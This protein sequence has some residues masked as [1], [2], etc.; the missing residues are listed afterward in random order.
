MRLRQF[1]NLDAGF[2]VE[3]AQDHDR[4]ALKSRSKSGFRVRVKAA[5][6]IPPRDLKSRTDELV[7]YRSTHSAQAQYGNVGFAMCWRVSCCWLHKF[8]HVYSVYALGR[9]ASNVSP[10]YPP[11]EVP[12]GT[13]NAALAV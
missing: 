8:W 11:G 12:G 2:T 1:T 9:Y 7:S 6:A 4:C 13:A 5:I 10:L 3:Q